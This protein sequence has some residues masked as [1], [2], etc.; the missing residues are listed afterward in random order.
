MPSCVAVG[1]PGNVLTI[2]V[3][4][5]WSRMRADEAW[6]VARSSGGHQADGV[7]HL[8][9]GLRLKWTRSFACHAMER[10][11]LVLILTA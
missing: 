3:L 2:L 11:G 4:V 9:Y 6:V 8:M 10:R 5:A 1:S 7:G